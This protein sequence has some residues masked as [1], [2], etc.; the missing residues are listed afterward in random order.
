MIIRLSLACTVALAFCANDSDGTR[1]RLPLLDAPDQS[2]LSSNQPLPEVFVTVEQSA[3]TKSGQLQMQSRLAIIRYVDGEFA[4]AVKPLPGGKKGFRF[5]A[6][7]PLD[8]K[9]L[10][11]ALHS[12]GAAANPGD[13]VQITALDFHEKEIVILIN[14]GGKK[15]FHALEHI[16]IGMGGQS[17]APPQDLHPQEGTG[18]TLILDYGRPLPDMSPDDL[19]QQ[20]SGFLDFSK[21]SSAVN[22]VETLPPQFQKAI[23][24]GEALVGMDR[25]MVIAAL[26]R[27]DRKVRERDPQSGA[28][29]EDWIYGNPP[30][31]TTFV[32]FVGDKVIRV[33]EFD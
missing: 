16:Q 2:V 6:G 14:G 19:K 20:L 26:G 25:E 31:K 1:L 22:W 18:T 8:E 24:D 17:S 30:L 29:T 10:N 11:A 5:E 27:P 32:T 7:K 9:S 13:T 3:T 21:H 33:K 12:Q 23:K 28:E 15:H 4:K